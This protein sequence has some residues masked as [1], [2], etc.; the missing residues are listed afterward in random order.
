[1]FISMQFYMMTMYDE[2]WDG[3]LEDLHFLA[4]TEYGNKTISTY[5]PEE[6]F[7]DV[8]ENRQN[9]M[10]NLYGNNNVIPLINNSAQNVVYLH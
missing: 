6:H 7:R 10:F 1:M 3:P 5:I 9:W 4:T 8:Q 2:I